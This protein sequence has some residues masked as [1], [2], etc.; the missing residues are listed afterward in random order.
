MAHKCN[1]DF[2]KST[3]FPVRIM[4]L[5]FTHGDHTWP[6]GGNP[7]NEGMKTTPKLTSVLP[8]FLCW[9]V[10]LEYRKALWEVCRHRLFCRNNALTPR[11][12]VCIPSK[13]NCPSTYLFS[14][15][16]LLLDP[17]ENYT[18]PFMKYILNKNI[19]LCMLY[20]YLTQFLRYALI[21]C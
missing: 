3:T 5:S 12:P 17:R 10:S 20:E 18:L 21:C 13:Y 16:L 19:L 4:C 15:F 9:G 2:Q 7:G 14:I 1:T 11:A 8:A 6:P